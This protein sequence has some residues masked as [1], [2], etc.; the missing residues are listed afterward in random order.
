MPGGDSALQ[1]RCVLQELRIASTGT[2]RCNISPMEEMMRRTL[3][4]V[5]LAIVVL[6]GGWYGYK[7]FEAMYS[8]DLERVLAAWGFDPL[9]PPGALRLGSLYAVDGDGHLRIVCEA[10]DQMIEG[11][12]IE[13]PVANQLIERTQAGNFSLQSDIDDALQTSITVAISV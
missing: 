6:C 3:L 13:D 9:H 1:R 8:N 10:D 7:Y 11:K 4:R 2:P 12:V 5:F